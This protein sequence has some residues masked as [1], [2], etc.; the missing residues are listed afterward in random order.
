MNEKENKKRAPSLRYSW[1]YMLLFAWRSLKEI[2]ENQGLQSASQMTDCIDE[3][4][5][6]RQKKI[7][8][9][10]ESYSL[11]IELAADFIMRRENERSERHEQPGRRNFSFGISHTDTYT[12]T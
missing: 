5:R 9:T 12:L 8:S 7:S 6:K 2:H 1:Y 10:N 11:I 3:N 4:E